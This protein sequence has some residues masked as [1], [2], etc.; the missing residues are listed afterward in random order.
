[1]STF[2]R[3]AVFYSIVL[4]FSWGWWGLLIW[5]GEI[6]APDSTASH[7]PGL[8]GPLVGAVLASILSCGPAGLLGTVRSWV[9]WPD[10]PMIVLSLILLP[11]VVAA[12]YFGGLAALGYSLPNS[13]EFFSYPGLTGSLASP[14]GLLI[15]LILNGYG[16]EAGWRGYLF[17]VLLPALGRIRATALVAALWLFWHLPLFWVNSTMMA[18]T[19]P[20]IVGWCIGL[21]LGAYALSHLYLLSG[22][23]VAAVAVWHVTYNICV[24][25]PATD[26]MTAVV[27]SS[28]VMVWGIGVIIAWMRNANV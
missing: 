21:V 5:R 20:M 28:A 22:R 25:T 24:A 27:V 1:M 2:R 14:L 9:R 4:T 6:V 16:E 12:I 26:G 10:H 13:A 23:S 8:M 11:L 17:E 18:M 3:V 7:L 15:V 19:G